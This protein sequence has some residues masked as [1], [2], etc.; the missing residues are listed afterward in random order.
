MFKLV[1]AFF[2]FIGCQQSSKETKADL[3]N[4]QIIKLDAVE[5][6]LIINEKV[7][8]DI[9]TLAKN[10]FNKYVKVNG[11]SGVATI[12][13]QSYEEIITEIDNG[14]RVDL[15]IKIFINIQKDSI[16]KTVYKLDINEYGEI[17]GDF[18]LNEFD[19]LTYESKI[20]LFNKLSKTLNSKL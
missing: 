4:I 8:Y 18:S 13:F 1:V 19:L 20:N 14:K 6:N 7:P 10:W 12:N 15:N 11:V 9:Q 5:K 16:T 17:V 3:T 2:L